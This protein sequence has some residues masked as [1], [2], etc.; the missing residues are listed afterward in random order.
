MAKSRPVPRRRRNRGV[1]RPVRT[2]VLHLLRSVLPHRGCWRRSPTAVTPI[3]VGAAFS[4]RGRAHVLFRFVLRAT[5]SAPGHLLRTPTPYSLSRATGRTWLSGPRRPLSLR[6]CAHGPYYPR[7]S[8]D[9][10]R[11]A[12][13]RTGGSRPASC[14]RAR[15]APASRRQR[16]LPARLRLRFRLR[17]LW[18]E[19]CWRRFRGAWAWRGRRDDGTGRRN[20]LRARCATPRSIGATARR[21]LFA[22]GLAHSTCPPPT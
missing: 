19:W 16:W 9:Q 12:S 13:A 18:P 6:C 17:P 15:S 5:G 11:C 8:A 10:E 4:S 20:A 21:P 2:H 22:A 1:R 14:C 7:S 3:S